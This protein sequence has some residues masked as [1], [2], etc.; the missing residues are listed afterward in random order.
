MNTSNN[1]Y[2]KNINTKQNK[3]SKVIENP[4][5]AEQPKPKHKPYRFR[6]GTVKK[7]EDNRYWKVVKKDK[8]KVWTRAS[9][10][11][12]MCQNFLKKM[13]QKNLK[14]Y[15]GGGYSS[16]RQAVAVSYS[17]TKRKFPSCKLVSNMKT[18][19]K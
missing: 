2:I 16:S 13:I 3:K 9:R 15:K 14:K 8:G 12:T 10:Q 6:L 18:K 19:K 4:N 17:M 7:G 11:E 1:I 5:V